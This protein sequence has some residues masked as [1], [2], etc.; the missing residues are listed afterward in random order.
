MTSTREFSSDFRQFALCNFLIAL[1]AIVA[2]VLQSQSFLQ[3]LPL[4]P[5]VIGQ[6]AATGLAHLLLFALFSAFEAALLE[7]VRFWTPDRT[8]VER[9]FFL[10]FFSGI[11][12]LLTLN[13]LW[14]PDS[15]FSRPL[16]PILSR[17]G[18]TL[19][20]GLSL[21]PLFLLLM[22]ALM[23]G[24]TRRPL[25]VAGLSGAAIAIAALPIPMPANTQGPSQKPNI[26]IIGIDSLPP[27][28]ITLKD[29]PTLA[30]FRENSVWFSETITPLA[31]TYPSWTTLL[32]GLYPLH[33]GARYNLMSPEKVARDKS[34][35]WTLQ[36]AGYQTHFATDD[37]RF[38]N[39]G[40]DFGFQRLT[41]PSVGASDILL[42]NFNDF[43][44]SN[45][46]INT[47]IGRLLFPW[48]HMNRASHFSYYP[49]TF[50]DALNH[51]LMRQDKSRPLFL[52][53]HFTLPH[54]PYTQADSALTEDFDAF[55]L[56]DNTN[57]YLK[58]VK[59][60]DAQLATL[61]QRLAHK[62]FLEN[63]LVILLSDHGETQFKDGSR[64]L[65]MGKYRGR[66]PGKLA[67]YF[68][69]HTEMVLEKSRGHGSDLLSPDQF[70][71]VLGVQRYQ[72]GILKTVAQRVSTR[73]SL[74]DIAPTIYASLKLQPSYPFDGISLLDT[75]EKGAPLPNRAFILESGELPNQSPS[76]EKAREY[77]QR[78]FRIVPETGRLEL[79]AKGLIELDALKLYG[80]I[81]NDML[82][83]LY[84]MG[85]YYWPVMLNL[86]SL[87]WA[88][89]QMPHPFSIET[90]RL[91]KYLNAFY[92][93]AFV[94]DA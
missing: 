54:W 91:L 66:Y 56:A 38:S 55:A 51:M 16:I 90:A 41:G 81:D 29:T 85:K 68:V 64:P 34:L 27:R 14:F 88:D 60:A 13:A 10:I 2:G 87:E 31:K 7:G 32:T 37:R 35:A 46:L 65:V 26:I 57:I 50:D 25:A 5:R 19:A 40:E 6:L 44:H 20:A 52:A 18:L 80:V 83:V 74:M 21:A 72:N 86:D 15:Q 94:Q 45:L 58:A 3:V 71:C 84:P 11:F 61:L 47:A 43:P 69:Q 73:V 59:R 79:T 30:R 78:L 70:H 8:T 17:T 12:S 33:H 4:P 9:A 23:I 63:S 24:F 49:Q 67:R 76:M 36:K 89:G 1:L 53:V 48:N 77:G 62:G 42:G 93:R 75:I 92:Q 28:Y 39:L 82:L 22:N